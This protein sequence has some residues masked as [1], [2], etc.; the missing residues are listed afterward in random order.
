MTARVAVP[1]HSLIT[2]LFGD[3]GKVNFARIEPTYAVLVKG[4]GRDTTLKHTS[5]RE[6]GDEQG[7][8]SRSGR[9]GNF[10]G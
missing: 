7:S 10:S 1:D 4:I 3:F 5:T 9:F 8:R 2:F 6:I